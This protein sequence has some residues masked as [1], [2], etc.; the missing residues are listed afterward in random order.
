[1][2]YNNIVETIPGK[3]FASRMNKKTREMLEIPE[4]SREV[5]KVNF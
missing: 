5:P 1:L 3:W 2:T 4:A